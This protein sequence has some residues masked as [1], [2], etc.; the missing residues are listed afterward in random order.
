MSFPPPPGFQQPS[1]PS[2]TRSQPPHGSLPPRP[3]SASYPP[4]GSP[5]AS[6]NAQRSPNY[7]SFTGFQPRSLAANQPYCSHSPAT[8]APY[9][10]GG[11][12]SAPA[13]SYSSGYQH[14]QNQYQQPPQLYQPQTSTYY[15][16]QQYGNGN[17][18]QSSVAQRSQYPLGQDQGTYGYGSGGSTLARHGDPTIDPETEAQIAQWQSAYMS[19][20]ESNQTVGGNNKTGPGRREDASSATGA[21][22]GPLG[23]AQRLHDGSATST[24]PSGVQTTSATPLPGQHNIPAQA[25]PGKTVV[26]SGGGQSWTDS[27]LLEWDPAHFRLFC[28]NLAGEVTDD[29]LL[30]AFSKYPSVQKARV[31]RDKRTEKS[32]GYGFVSFSDGEDYFR[33]AREMQ[34]KY[35]GSHPVLLRRAMTEIRPVV[36]GKGGAKGQKKGNNAPGGG[37]GG[38]KTTKA[39]GKAADG[40][41][42]KK[43]A[44]T[45]G[46]LRVLG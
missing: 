40:G 2:S 11:G 35:I 22:T 13:A 33:A 19:K 20:E 36:A 18:G 8:S 43:Q 44:K 30:K 9:S 39:G 24:P 12:Y 15:S 6:G 31:I 42:Q 27:T 32:K 28:G 10:S 34:G 7:N 21:N 25:G 37:I 1:R 45:K 16:Q 23:N 14:P 17:Y 5:G 41:V 3:P 29:S 4:S 46:G 38:G 26:R